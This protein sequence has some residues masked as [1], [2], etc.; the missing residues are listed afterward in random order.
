MASDNSCDL[1]DRAPLAKSSNNHDECYESL[2][3][4]GLPLFVSV[5][6]KLHKLRKLR[7]KWILYWLL[8]ARNQ[9][10]SSI[11]TFPLAVR[12]ELFDFGT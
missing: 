11:W 12:Y 6:D 10:R 5:C 2:L 1:V 8:M 9:L 3:V 4:L 7:I